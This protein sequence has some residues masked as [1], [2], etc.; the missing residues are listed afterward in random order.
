MG[1]SNQ[2]CK[3]DWAGSIEW[4]VSEAGDDEWTGVRLSWSRN[5]G[6]A[7]VVDEGTGVNGVAAGVG[8]SSRGNPDECRRD[9]ISAA[10]GPVV[11]GCAMSGDSITI[12]EARLASR[13]SK[14]A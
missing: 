9:R 2:A 6:E 5:G 7:A 3:A 1:W 4:V 10:A 14:R 8:K 13:E 12:R 11:G